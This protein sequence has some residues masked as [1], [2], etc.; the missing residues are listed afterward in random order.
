MVSLTEHQR[1]LA[2][3]KLML[4]NERSAQNGTFIEIYIDKSIKE[5]LEQVKSDPSDGSKE[6]YRRLYKSKTCSNVGKSWQRMLLT[7]NTK[8]SFDK[9]RTAFRFCIAEEIKSLRK[10]AEKFSKA[11]DY[12]SANR[13]TKEAFYLAIK[14]EDEFLSDNKITFSD[15]QD[16]HSFERKSLSKR[17]T[18]KNAPSVDEVF[19]K[20]KPAFLKQHAA[21]FM[22]INRF[23]I[24][25]SE[26]QKGVR[27]KY[28]GGRIF[29]IIKGSKIA[30][31]RGQEV[32]VVGYQPDLSNTADKILM[33]LLK[34]NNNDLAV[35]QTQKK[36]N[37]L[38]KH[39]N[40]YHPGFSLY[41][42]RHKF[43]SDL[44]KSGA[45]RKQI[46]EAM[47]H[48]NTVSQ[49]SYGYSKQGESS[50]QF[51]AQANN[52][53]RVKQDI[54]Q[55]LQ[56]QNESVGSRIAEAKSK[57]AAASRTSIKRPKLTPFEKGK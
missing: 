37:A 43:A 55:Y 17:K 21:S 31:D 53:V 13:L 26:M 28:E 34:E 2:D 47:G 56:P 6:Q 50:R 12:E 33:G 27:L 24:R 16:R 7:C 52:E 20:M 4:A 41:S 35:V 51:V 36:Y 30:A 1:G 19:D 46:A 38:R 54:K 49:E 5:V 14:F 44:K 25:P 8:A 10:Q 45:S 3:A 48:R 42:Y 39:F 40:K 29:A 15:V 11:K 22:V 9:T 23:G 18:A 57:A 32:R